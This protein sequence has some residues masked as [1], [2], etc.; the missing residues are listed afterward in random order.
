MGGFGP[1]RDAIFMFGK[2]FYSLWDREGAR[3]TRNNATPRISITQPRRRAA[4]AKPSIDVAAAII[5]ACSAAWT[6]FDTMQARRRRALLPRVSTR[7]ARPG[8]HNLK[9]SPV[10]GH[11]RA[12]CTGTRRDRNLQTHSNGPTREAMQPT[13]QRRGVVVD[14]SQRGHCRLS[15]RS[16]PTARDMAG[17]RT[18]RQ[19]DTIDSVWQNPS[20]AGGSTGRPR[21]QLAH[22][23]HCRRRAPRSV[24]SAACVVTP[25]HTFH[26][27]APR[28]SKEGAR[29]VALTLPAAQSRAPPSPRAANGKTRP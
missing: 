25:C 19:T 10:A 29:D 22:C 27:R 28:Q 26:A 12:R 13:L 14:C 3:S 17:S 4:V 5:A 6:L 16:P 11:R 24:Q 21:C 18:A 7:Y 9:T 8:T 1:S 20:W 23:V 2:N 15:L